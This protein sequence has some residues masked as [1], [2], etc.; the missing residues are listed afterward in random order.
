MSKFAVIIAAAGKSSRFRD[1]HYKKPFVRL[2]QKAV[3]LYSAERFQNRGDV[4]QVILVIAPEDRDEFTSLFG[5]NVAIMG[6]DVV[7]GG[8]ERADSVQNAL[9]KVGSDIQFV[10]I[11]DAARPCV[12]EEDIEAV[13]AA[14]EKSNAAI[15]ATPVTSTLKASKNGV[16]SETLPRSDKWLAQTPQVFR[17]EDLVNAY[18]NS[19]SDRPTDES[20]LMEQNGIQVTIVEGSPLNIKIT[21]KDDLR[22]AKAILKSAAPVKF[23]AP[24]HP[25]ADGDL[26]R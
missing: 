24:N 11:H 14:A 13:F 18:R 1:K 6:I 12:S 10:A 19:G 23:D 16:V 8:K 20:A 17:K 3:W 5:P 2:D 15:L 4:K 25:F 7:E 26:W 22:L 9:G 21:T